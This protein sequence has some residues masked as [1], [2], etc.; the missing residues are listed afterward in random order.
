MMPRHAG[1]AR[2]GNRGNSR[3][4]SVRIR[5]RTVLARD[6]RRHHHFDHLGLRFPLAGL[7]ESGFEAVAADIGLPVSTLWTAPMPRRPPSRVR[8]PAVFRRLVMDLRC[9]HSPRPGGRSADG[10]LILFGFHKKSTT[11]RFTRRPST[12][13]LTTTISAT[14]AL[15]SCSPHRAPNGI[16]CF[17]HM[18]DLRFELSDLRL[19]TPMTKSCVLKGKLPL[20]IE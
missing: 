11:G 20:A 6:D 14:A 15:L 18:C 7:P 16:P 5:L 2:A 9:H 4:L 17:P 12:S 13:T 10:I 3:P 1:R 8:I 19:G